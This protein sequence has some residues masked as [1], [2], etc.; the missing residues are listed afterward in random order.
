MVATGCSSGK[1]PQCFSFV[2]RVGHMLKK[3]GATLKRDVWA[4]P[5]GVLLHAEIA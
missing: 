4:I 2:G 5:S 3:I 1:A